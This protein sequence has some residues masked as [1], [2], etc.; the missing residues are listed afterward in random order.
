MSVARFFLWMCRPENTTTCG[1]SNCNP[2]VSISLCSSDPLLSPDKPVLHIN[3]FVGEFFVTITVL[4]E[5]SQR[6]SG[7]EKEGFSARAALNGCNG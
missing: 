2:I 7:K 4:R 5:K 1:N 6:R 3:Y